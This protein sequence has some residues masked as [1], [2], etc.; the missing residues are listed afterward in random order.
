[1]S[2]VHIPRFSCLARGESWGKSRG[3]GAMGGP[4]LMASAWV[5]ASLLGSWVLTLVW[6]LES[7]GGRGGLKKLS[8]WF[9]VHVKGAQS[10]LTLCDPMDYTVPGILQARILE[11]GV[12]AF[13]RGLSQS[14]DR[15]QVSRIAG[16]FF[17]S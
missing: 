14:R 10:C 2:G 9:C 4:D 13:S 7:P 1:M 12:F 15:T 8:A 5:S 11:W 3:R 16:R 6:A 17:T